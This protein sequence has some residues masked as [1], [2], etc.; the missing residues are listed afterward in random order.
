MSGNNTY[1]GNTTIAEGEW[2]ANDNS[3]SHHIVKKGAILT[4]GNQYPTIELKSLNNQGTLSVNLSNL[5]INGNLN[6][7]NG[8]VEQAIGTK[9]DVSG[10]ANLTNA[11]WV[12]TGIKKDYVTKAGQTEILLNAKNISGKDGF[13][14]FVANANLGEL[15]NQKYDLNDTQL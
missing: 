8:A 14:F 3:Q 13:Q 9:I 1:T 4:I 12:L 11:S 7:A 6:N 10:S 15:I 2:V 5:K